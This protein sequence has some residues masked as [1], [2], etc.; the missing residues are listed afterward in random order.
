MLN[1][2]TYSQILKAAGHIEEL[3]PP[4]LKELS[5][6]KEEALLPSDEQYVC[7]YHL[8]T[9]GIFPIA[10]KTSELRVDEYYLRFEAMSAL[11]GYSYRQMT[12]LFVINQAGIL[13]GNYETDHKQLVVF[14]NRSIDGQWVSAIKWLGLAEQLNAYNWTLLCQLPPSIV[15]L[16]ARELLALYKGNQYWFTAERVEKIAR[17]VD[18]KTLVVKITRLL[19][20]QKLTADSLDSLLSAEGACDLLRRT[21][22]E[23]PALSGAPKPPSP[24]G[25]ASVPP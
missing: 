21:S 20:T 13:S 3:I 25:P 7:L 17:S 14:N 23:L 12:V 16:Y 6:A 8:L 5:N 4:E 24:H 15:R 22:D 9:K 18:R 2:I 19:S 11:F 10:H 1:S